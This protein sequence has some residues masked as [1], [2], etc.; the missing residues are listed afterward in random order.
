P[1]TT[2]QITGSLPG[3]GAQMFG[4]TWGGGDFYVSTTNTPGDT[5]LFLFNAGGNGVQGNDDGIAFAGPA[6]LQ[7]S[8]L[9]AGNYFL[10]VSFYD[11]DPFDASNNLMFQSFPFQTLY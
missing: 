1:G 7:V 3:S 5:Q 9:A 8:G 10:G 4:F 2:T 6:Y 11:H